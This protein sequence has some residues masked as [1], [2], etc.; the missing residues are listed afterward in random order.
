MNQNL[1][2]EEKDKLIEQQDKEIQRLQAQLTNFQKHIVKMVTGGNCDEALKEIIKSKDEQISLLQSAESASDNKE[3]EQ[4]RKANKELE[5][6]LSLFT[7]GAPWQK[8]VNAHTLK[9]YEKMAHAISLTVRGM[10]PKEIVAKLY[11]DDDIAISGKTVTRA[12]SVKEDDDKERVMKVVSLFPN[13]FK[14]R[15]VTE[16]AVLQWFSAERIK[17]LHLVSREEL[18]EEYEL[19]GTEIQPDKYVLGTYFNP[20]DIKKYLDEN[21]WGE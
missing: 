9:K 1:T 16:D 5:A 8:A 20:N 6:Q 12:I 15:G 11:E 13:I 17:K 4:L 10:K 2:S 18:S 19:K 7:E 14:E 3:V 21:S